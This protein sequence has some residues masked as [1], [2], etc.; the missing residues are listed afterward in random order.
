MPAAARSYADFLLGQSS[1]APNPFGCSF[2][3]RQNPKPTVA[4]LFVL[5]YKKSSRNLCFRFFQVK[6]KVHD[7]FSSL[8]KP[9]S[10]AGGNF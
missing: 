7:F 6:E 1:N 3:V 4:Q 5:P 8:E 9:K 2:F 10:Y